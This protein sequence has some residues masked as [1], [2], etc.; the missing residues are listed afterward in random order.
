MTTAASKYNSNNTTSCKDR[1]RASEAFCNG[2][3]KESKIFN[4]LES[5]PLQRMEGGCSVFV[6]IFASQHHHHGL[7]HG[8]GANATKYLLCKCF[9]FFFGPR[10]KIDFIVDAF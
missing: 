10:G 4:K 8:K 2:N 6:D 9:C 3:Q 7:G 5:L 1:D